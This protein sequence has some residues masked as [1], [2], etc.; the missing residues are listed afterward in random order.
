MK[1]KQISDV[2]IDDLE[3]HI[4]NENKKDLDILIVPIIIE[5][6]K[7]IFIFLKIRKIAKIKTHKDTN[8]LEIQVQCPYCQ[9]IGTQDRVTRNYFCPICN[10][11]SYIIISVGLSSYLIHKSNNRIINKHCKISKG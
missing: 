10:K 8:S 2:H 3:F 9:S 6:I 7:D 4:Y 1:E 11:K 5:Y